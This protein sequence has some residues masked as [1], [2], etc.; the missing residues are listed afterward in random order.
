MFRPPPLLPGDKV[1]LV[2]PSGIIENSY[3]ENAIQILRSWGLN[4]VVGKHVLS[5]CGYFAGN[6]E[7]RAED[8]QKALD[9]EDVRAIFCTRGGYGSLRIVEKLDYSK[10]QGTLKWLVG[11]HK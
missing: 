10:F 8:M 4:P 3:I 2:S 5:Q 1:A 7:E 6:D 11:N 9:D